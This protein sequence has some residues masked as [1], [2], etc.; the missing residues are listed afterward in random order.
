MNARFL[1]VHRV[2][3]G[4]VRTKENIYTIFPKLLETLQKAGGGGGGKNVTRK[5]RKKK[6]F[7]RARHDCSHELRAAMD[8]CVKNRPV[9]SQT[10][11]EK[12]LVAE[13]AL[14]HHD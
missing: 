8:I 1:A 13:E 12:W 3:G 14:S 7:L 11:M 9:K 4:G 10:W 5:N 6:N 2:S